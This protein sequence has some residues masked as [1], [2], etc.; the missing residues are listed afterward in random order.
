MKKETRPYSPEAYPFTPPGTQR[1]GSQSATCPFPFY[2][3]TT[4]EPNLDAAY[5]VPLHPFHF[6]FIFISSFF[7]AEPEIIPYFYQ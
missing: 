2:I 7:R 1:A 3:D 6:I 5:P 4:R